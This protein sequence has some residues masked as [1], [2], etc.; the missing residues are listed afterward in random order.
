MSSGPR[1]EA[2]RPRA[3]SHRMAEPPAILRWNGKEIELP[4]VRGTEDEFAI[5]ISKLRA[6]TGLITL[7]YGYVN[8]G[9]TE[10]AITYI[11]GD[12]G[13]L[14]YR[15]YDIEALA[16][17]EHPSFL[18]TAYLLIYGELPTPAERGEVK[19]QKSMRSHV[20]SRNETHY[21]T[22]LRAA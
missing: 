1:N 10:S 18:E 7:D 13:F 9:A 14:R 15:G 4:I 2:I 16:D 21:S 11:D 20:K 17:Q 3:R 8:T 5:D 19:I 6:Q 22:R 12:A